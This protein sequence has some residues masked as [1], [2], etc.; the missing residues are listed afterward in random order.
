MTDTPTIRR[1]VD[2]ATERRPDDPLFAD[3]L[4]AYYGELPEFD[5]DDRHDADLYAVAL[6]HHSLGR[7]RTPGDTFVQVLS[8]DRDRDGWHSDRS[9][10]L[11]VTDDVPFLV[12][13][14]RMVL[15]RHQVAT[16]LLVHPMLFATRDPAGELVGVA[17]AAADDSPYGV[18]LEAW[19]QV[20]ID[21]CDPER[22]EVLRADIAEA[23]ALVHSIVGDFDAMRSRMGAFRDLDPLLEWLASR[24]F[25]F[26]GAATYDVVDGEVR[27]REG[28]ALGTLTPDSP[29]DPD[30]NIDGEVVS[31]A[32]SSRV[33]IIHRPAR[34]TVVTVRADEPDGPAF[35]R[36]VGLLASTV[37]RQSVLTIPS[38]G[39]RARA[40]LG[41]AA[42]GAE[43]HTGR[44]MR[45]VLETLPRDLAFELD[46]DSLA[47]LV[48]DVVG[49]QERQIV[50]VFDVPEPV[51]ALSTMLVYLPK[52]RFN[53]QLPEQVAERVAEAYGTTPRDLESF[54]GTSNLARIT[55]TLERAAETPDL[56]ELSDQVDSFSTAWLDRVHDVAV[57]EFG[58]S[59]GT[60]LVQRIGPAAPAAYRT[61]VDP[62]TA[63]GDFARLDALIEGER[64]TVC[65]FV[66]HVDAVEGVWRM[67]VFRRDHP[68]AL[69]DMLPLL[70]HL[71]LRALDEHPYCFPLAGGSCF[72]YDIGVRVPENVTIGDR[73][74]AEVREALVGL[75]AGDIEPDGFNRL[76]LLGGLTARQVNVLR[77]YA[78]YAHQIGFTFSQGYIEE[79]FARLPH[80]A[81]LLVDLFEIRFDPDRDEAE[82]AVVVEATRSAVL[83]ALDDVPSLDDD[84]IGRM[85]LA[86]IQATLRTN[87]YQGR[88]TLAFK[89][90][91][92]EVPD[93]PEPRPAFEIF[94]S[95]ARVEGVHL[96]GGPIAR[97][98][99]RW[100]DR[101]E[102]YRTEVLGLVKAQM[103]KNAV[104]VP[105]GAKGG[106]VVKR[107]KAT[108]AENREEAVEC[109]KMFVRGLLDL[110]DNVVAGEIVPPDRTARYDGDD[111]YLVVAADKGTATFSDT[112]NEVAA[113][114][115]FWLG[116]A[117]ASGGSAGYDH[118]AM[119]I[120]ARGA[121]ESVRRH[122]MVLG[123]N[124]DTDELTA[125][126]IGDMSGDV[127][128]NGML[129]SPHLKLV[130]AFDHRHIFIDPDPDP[131]ASFVERQRLF[132][133]PRSSWAEYDAE[134]ISEGGG[135]FPRTQK[136]IPISTQARE[137]LGVEAEQMT[138]NELI[139][140]I[141]CA[142]VDLLWN[143]G[144]GTYV[145]ATSESNSEVGDRANDALR[146]DATE[147]R[148]KIIGEG[149]NLGITQ[150]ARV[151]Y[152]IGGGLVYTDAIDNSAGVD[153][154][155]HEVNIKILLGDVMATG[156]MTLKQRNEL[157]EEMTDEVAELVLD[158]NRAQTLALLI[159]RTQGLPMVNVHARYLDLLEREGW[160]DRSLEFLP[161]DKEIAERQS[162][163]SG[164]RAPELAVM[165]AYTKNA[166][167][168]EI[169]KTDL[170]DEP[171]LEADLVN[172]FPT[173]L[174]ERFR[175]RMTTHRLRREI[176]A[177][178]LM[179][180]MVN[181]SG[182]SYDHRMTEDTGASVTDV[183]RAWLTVREVLGFHE[184]WDEIAELDG[185]TLEDQLELFLDCRRTAERCSLWFMRHRRPPVDV[186][187]ESDRFR[188]PVRELSGELLECLRGPMRTAADTMVAARIEQGVP[189]ELAERSAVWRLL[190]TTFDVIEL[191]DRTGAPPIAA[192]STYWEVFDRFELMWLWDAVGA[193]PR[194]DRWQTQARSAL[195]D[196]LLTALAELTD[197]VMETGDRS[198]DAWIDANERA[199][200]RAITMLTEIRRAESFDVTN[201]SVALRQ[202]R[203]LA[204]TSVRES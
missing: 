87:A 109:Y 63:V 202:L 75:L 58:E 145:K 188:E 169:M 42:S 67:R 59:R 186:S 66:R 176:A 38:V 158:N 89:L 44:S 77:A 76:I 170:P 53:A 22:A 148:C 97:G 36:F 4:R 123:K 49:L 71:G 82:R 151:E 153:C 114:Y 48:I 85:F 107:R 74:H 190:H 105:V 104:I 194:S 147:L 160:L 116:D 129:R 52:S 80:L 94:V 164:L 102:D 100:S 65:A 64:D 46:T 128:G 174:R 5:V 101:P 142:P 1:V 54:L 199:V 127:F 177:T 180:Q 69:S 30:I 37:Y 55:F 61:G 24:H 136:S 163:G 122:A 40:V 17:S 134:L 78:R 183:T 111:P 90:D 171:A 31:V 19:T 143:G 41:L 83:G 159:A 149:G 121:W 196:D 201:L 11:L 167:I 91:P 81:R 150:L 35:H 20:E 130:A 92:S 99:L 112:A 3:F 7:N 166:N 96:R 98:G 2:L 198:V 133:I 18:H 72:V 68:I 139:K 88:P 144:V 33:S 12:D 187:V 51:G 117:F 47:R 184:W 157:L 56:D 189:A 50:R 126:G 26:L 204:L 86:M 181:L 193:L 108:A 10:V 43:T 124:V 156:D 185:L 178:E 70:G 25:V 8:P 137:V 62:Q 197:N 28:S 154:S 84:R 131:A 15:E 79:S 146:A 161:S 113:E 95:S 57:H 173:P 120:T 73:R 14:V 106:F 195:R 155:D 135:V 192:A 23:V 118:K 110:T 39:E 179:N 6:A 191:A 103:V 141:L 21:R 27:C 93:L 60:S 115:G 165:I 172:Y 200:D 125:V 9:V 16:H 140:A 203:N 34:M 13:T 132:Q 32:R 168:S 138:P 29:V 152:A 175:D 119:G 162:N 182:I 45:N